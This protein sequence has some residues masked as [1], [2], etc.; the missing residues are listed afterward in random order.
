MK[1]EFAISTDREVVQEFLTRVRSAEKRGFNPKGQFSEAELRAFE[2]GKP[3]H[4]TSS[5]KRGK[6][7][8]TESDRKRSAEMHKKLSAEEQERKQ[9][10][11]R[12]DAWR[13]ERITNQKIESAGICTVSQSEAK[14]TICIVV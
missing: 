8:F 1:R 7:E 9:R 10:E 3:V 11:I 13:K 6:L 5:E 14:T 4:V 12:L 2:T